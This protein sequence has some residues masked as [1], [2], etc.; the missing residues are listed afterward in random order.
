VEIQAVRPPKVGAQP[1]PPDR[2]GEIAPD[3][4]GSG[5]PGAYP[6]LPSRALSTAYAGRDAGLDMRIITETTCNHSRI[7]GIAGFA[8]QVSRKAREK[9]S[10]TG[11]MM[12]SKNVRSPVLM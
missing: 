3:G 11:F 8:I 12:Y 4:P 2:T 7:F 1:N 10:N 9:L 5:P 6:S